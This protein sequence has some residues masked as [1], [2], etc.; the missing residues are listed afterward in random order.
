MDNNQQKP[1]EEDPKVSELKDNP[2]VS[3]LQ[4]DSTLNIAIVLASM[5]MIAMAVLIF[6]M[7]GMARMHLSVVTFLFFGLFLSLL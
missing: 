3:F 2:L 7:E 6:F 1:R 4:S 5:G